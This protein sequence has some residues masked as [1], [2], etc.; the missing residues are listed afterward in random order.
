MVKEFKEFIQRGNVLDMAV[1]VIMGGAIGAIVTS[2]VND[3]LMPIVGIFLGGLD[4][5]NLSFEINDVSINYGSFI[6]SAVNFFII[7]ICIFTIVKLLN[8]FLAKAEKVEKPKK[9][10]V[11]E[12][13]KLLREIRNELKKKK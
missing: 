3:V 8:R 6:Q 1:G 7:A 13:I 10:E 11:P 12:D 4:F 2:L 9:V 5:A